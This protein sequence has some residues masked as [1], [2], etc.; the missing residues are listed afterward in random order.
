[1]IKEKDWEKQEKPF[2]KL[3]DAM[4]KI[5]DATKSM[6]ENKNG[7]KKDDS[8]NQINGAATGLLDADKSVSA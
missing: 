7:G 3:Q 6:E 4:S 2:K 5:R 8:E 1:L